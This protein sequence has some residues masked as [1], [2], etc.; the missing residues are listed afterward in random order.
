MMN[1]QKIQ[2]QWRRR[3]TASCVLRKEICR[4]DEE[5]GRKTSLAAAA[6]FENDDP[7]VTAAMPLVQ[8]VSR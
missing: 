4:S 2:T 1:G 3:R 7:F 5:G 6:D 8:Q